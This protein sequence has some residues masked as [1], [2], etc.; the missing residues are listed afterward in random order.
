MSNLHGQDRHFVFP[1]ENLHLEKWSPSY[2]FH[3]QYR[4][5]DF[6]EPIVWSL[7]AT[8]DS[9]SA[10]FGDENWECRFFFQFFLWF[11]S[12]PSS[13]ISKILCLLEVDWCGGFSLNMLVLDMLKSHR[14]CI[15]KSELRGS[16]CLQ[17]Y[18]NTGKKSNHENYCRFWYILDRK[19]FLKGQK[20]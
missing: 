17:Q 6:G 1:T 4:E 13:P 16:K 18:L 15:G 10:T 8:L 20:Q 9:S 2:W 7:S 12:L 19:W 3:N 14:I 11:F 5:I